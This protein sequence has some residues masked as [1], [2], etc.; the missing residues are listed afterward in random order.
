MHLQNT[1][2]FLFFIEEISVVLKN[3]DKDRCYGEVH[4]RVKQAMRAVCA[5]NW[6]KADAEVVCRE[7]RCG[8]VGSTQVPLRVR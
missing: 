1:L 6:T 7:L 2:N 4:I 5:S 3:Q 8:R